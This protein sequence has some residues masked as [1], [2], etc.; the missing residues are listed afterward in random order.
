MFVKILK[1]K[2]VCSPGSMVYYFIK[3]MK[4]IKQI[5]SLVSTHRGKTVPCF[6][7]L[8]IWRGFNGIYATDVTRQ[9]ETLISP[10][11]SSC[12]GTCLCSYIETGLSSACYLQNISM[13]TTTKQ[14]SLPNYLGSFCIPW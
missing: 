5:I 2:V 11:T 3:S 14:H 1:H 8:L 12:P 9:Q 13:G 10:K 4:G 7:K 6:L